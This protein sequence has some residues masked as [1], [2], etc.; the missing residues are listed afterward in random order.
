M[1]ALTKRQQVNEIIA[2]G[3][4]PLYFFNTYAKIQHPQRGIILFDTHPFQDDCVAAFR[5]NRFNIILKARQLG[6]STVTAAYAVWEAIFHKGKTILV[7]ATK[8]PTAQ[9]F[10]KKVKVVLENLPPWLLLPKI[11]GSSKST[12]EFDNGSSITAIPTSPDAGRS[13]ALSL[14]IVDEAAFIRDFEEIWTGLWPTLTTGGS[15][16]V[17]STPNGVGG[18]YY[19]L[20]TDAESGQ[21]DFHAIRL[22]WNVHPEHDEAWFDKETRGMPRRDIAQEHLCDFLS[23]GETFL[24]PEDL[25]YLRESI[26][27][28]V[29][30]AGFD[31]NVWI[32][33][34]PVPSRK[35]V[36]SADVARGDG[37]DYSTFHVLDTDDCSVAAEYMGKIPPDKLAEMLD[38]WGRTYNTALLCPENNTFGYMTCSWLK[39]AKYPRI[40]YQT[41]RGD[42][43]EY[44]PLKDAELPGFSTQQKTRALILGKLEELIR[45]KVVR[46][47]SRRFYEEMQAF[48]WNGG[49]AQA[50]NDSHDDLIMSMAIGTWLI[51]GGNKVSDD[52][53]NMAYAM[54]KATSKGSRSS[55]EI[56]GDL[57]SVKPLVNPQIIGSNPHSVYRPKNSPDRQQSVPIGAINDF[58]WLLK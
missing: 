38:E 57:A 20:W 52:A 15:A 12:V 10:I 46:S 49:K 8:L 28:P 22:P 4:D 18:R 9:N 30:R 24:Q 32:W 34:E 2:C 37:G 19:R 14:L 53:R 51:E 41:C 50:A 29:R 27:P 56:S 1:P 48:V 23:S 13:E 5:Q 44:I 58:S 43:F 3:Q 45:N 21:N 55:D 35:Y 40:Y 7:I 42:P 16:I 54:L 6:L 25:V 17:L 36:I 33:E 47:K 11:T 31:H 26:E 39:S